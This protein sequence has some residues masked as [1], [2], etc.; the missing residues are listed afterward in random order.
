MASQ[1]PKCHQPVDEDYIC[2]AGIEF[3]WRCN[4]CRKR[5]RGFAIPFGKCLCGG[6]LTRIEGKESAVEERLLALQ[7]A[8]QIEVEAVHFYHH[9]AEAV[10]DPQVSDFFENMS[11]MEKEHAQ[12]LNE[13]YHLHVDEEGFLDAKGPI[14]RPFFDDLRFFSET[15]DLRSLYN[16]AITLEMRTLNFFLEKSKTLPEGAER[17]LYEELAAE[18]REH[19]AILE[20]E[21]DR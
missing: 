11:R 15:G 5:T 7:Q 2:C 4:R 1:C 12:E 16:C 8:F 3:Q 19:I 14:P 21:R 18:E 10:D 17:L 6:D 9:L 13:K 20:S